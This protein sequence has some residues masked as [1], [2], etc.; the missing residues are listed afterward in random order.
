MLLGDHRLVLQASNG[1]GAAP[2]RYMP[3]YSGV[4]C[5]AKEETPGLLECAPGELQA[6]LAD[7]IGR[8]SVIAGH[9]VESSTDPDAGG[10]TGSLQVAISPY[11]LFGHP[12]GDEDDVGLR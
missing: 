5:I 8:G 11:V 9:H 4:S 1:R 12:V 6:Q 10:G 7:P 2:G 3:E